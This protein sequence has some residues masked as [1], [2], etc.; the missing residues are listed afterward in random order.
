MARTRFSTTSEFPIDTYANAGG[1]FGR[2][3]PGGGMR[4]GAPVNNALAQAL[5]GIVRPEVGGSFNAPAIRSNYRPTTIAQSP[6]LRDPLQQVVPSAQGG[7]GG[8]RDLGGAAK[9]AGLQKLGQGI[10]QAMKA[11]AAKRAAGQAALANVNALPGNSPVFGR[12][13][14]PAAGGGAGNPAGLGATPAAPYSPSPVGAAG[15][16]P[17]F[18]QNPLEPRGPVPPIGAAG[19]LPAFAQGGATGSTVAGGPLSVGQF[20]Q[21]IKAG[22]AVPY[23][24]Q[25]STGAI[26][27]YGLTGD[28]IKQWAPG[29][30][31]PTD[32][33][34][35]MNS[36]ALQD[37]LATYAASQM[38]DR[39]GDW[40]KVAN[41]WLTGSPTR[42][43][44]S[45]GNMSPAAYDAKVMNAAKAAQGVPTTA[46]LSTPSAS[47]YAAAGPASPTP[48]TSQFAGPGAQSVIP[49]QG[50]PHAP[51]FDPSSVPFHRTPEIDQP[52]SAAPNEPDIGGAVKGNLF[53]PYAPQAP[54][55]AASVP[56]PQPPQP[57]LI[58]G[59]QPGVYPMPDQGP[60]GMND[61]Q[62]NPLAAALAGQGDPNAAPAMNPNI[63]A[64]LNGDPFGFGGAPTPDFAMPD[65]GGSLFG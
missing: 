54:S 15:D 57:P 25:S 36:P 44:S 27:A 35:Y 53:T 41:T 11:W 63:V 14:A 46:G 37:Q 40:G 48:P 50:D 2:D 51:G 8:A 55:G 3:L 28:F 47:A 21:G 23:S 64:L 12:P 60:Q 52:S 31:L 59:G 13:S 43:Y 6:A 16:T 7:G 24:G 20:L 29:A 49:G 33:A 22:E 38:H 32:R 26:G 34:S 9:A 1:T 58:N 5:A 18:E 56:I 10:E 45:P 61:A 4:P 19:S 30:G 42:T 62:Q 17:I 39:Y 65:F